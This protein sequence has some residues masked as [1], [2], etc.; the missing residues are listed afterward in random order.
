MF[1]EIAQK[2]ITMIEEDE[3][4]RTPMVEQFSD[5]I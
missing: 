1:E 2:K 5:D 4:V 3:N